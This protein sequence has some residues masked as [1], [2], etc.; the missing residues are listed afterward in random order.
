MSVGLSKCIA[1]TWAMKCIAAASSHA[2]AGGR[3]VIRAGVEQRRNALE[4]LAARIDAIDI[5]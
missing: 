2:D 3:R 4:K 1:A 5:V